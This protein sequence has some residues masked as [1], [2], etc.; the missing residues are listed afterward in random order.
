MN[1]K[2]IPLAVAA[3]LSLCAGAASAAEERVYRVDDDAVYRLGRAPDWNVSAADGMCRL[4]LWVDDRARVQLHGDQIVVTTESGKRAFDEG[5]VCTQPLPLRSVDNFH[6][7]VVRARGNVLKVRA[8]DPHNDY[9][10]ALTIVDPQ[11]GGDNYDLVIAWH[12]PGMAGPPVAANE[13]YPY[14]DATRACQDRVRAEFLRR[15]ADLGA[16]MEFHGVATRDDDGVDRERIRGEGWARDRT[17]S[18]PVTYECEINR[19]TDRVLSASY[20]VG[21]LPRVSSLR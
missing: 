10:G 6:V 14:F 17:Q 8:P 1:E 7:E 18:R 21:G 5:S 15:N 13:P 12:N 16:Y 20:D 4:H 3:A 2:L 9:T 11:D 19:R